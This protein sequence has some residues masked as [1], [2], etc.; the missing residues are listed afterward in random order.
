VTS[1][2]FNG[3]GEWLRCQLHAHTT[4]SDGV[5]SPAE[6]ADHYADAGYDVLAI[7]DH[8]HVT[9]HDH[10]RILVIG[11]SELSARAGDGWEAEVLA[12]GAPG[13]PEA[14]E[15]FPDLEAAARWV[16]EN[17]G[18]PFLAHPYWSGLDP[19]EY[20]AAPSLCGIETFNGGSELENGTGSSAAFWDAILNQGAP[21]L[22]VACDDCHYP[23]RDS[24]L[25][26]TM[27][28]ARE[29]TR[30]AVLDALRRGWFYG[31]AG[32]EIRDVRIGADGIEV[33]TSPARAITL[34]AAPWEGG[35]VNADNEPANWRATVLERDGDGWIVAARLRFPERCGWGR[36]E[37]LGADHRP[38]WSN[39]LVLPTDPGGPDANLG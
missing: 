16:R 17:G 29:R 7:T 4:N 37:V 12:L 5:A 20:L 13:L 39:P 35:R 23:G 34:R 9:G 14:R 30:E 26:W 25:G 15:H 18:V 11:S 22:G 10:D 27:V 21:C 8:W 19:S 31:S 6:L 3:T 33:R 32:P 38:A 2:P 24:R 1:G 28:H 36:I